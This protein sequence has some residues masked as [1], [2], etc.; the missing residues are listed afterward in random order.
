MK[1]KYCTDCGRFS[2]N[3]G[4]YCAYC[5]SR[6]G[7]SLLAPCCSCGEY[8][9]VNHKFCIY[10]GAECE[11]VK[12][13]FCTFYE[14]DEED[15]SAC[16][17]KNI[18]VS[19]DDYEFD[20]DGKAADEIIGFVNA[21]FASASAQLGKL[22]DDFRKFV[23]DFGTIVKDYDK[24]KKSCEIIEGLALDLE[25]CNGMR[26]IRT[27]NGYELPENCCSEKDII[28]IPEGVNIIG[29]RAFENDTQLNNLV[30]P[31]SVVRIGR[32]AFKNS[33]LVCVRIPKCVKIIDD[34]A[35]CF[36]NKIEKV[37][38]ESGPEHIGEY[39]FYGC[40]SLK[41]V[42]LPENIGS[43]GTCAFGYIQDEYGES[44]KKMEDFDIICLGGAGRDYGHENGFSLF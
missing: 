42:I 32:D 7:T 35:F 18:I 8:I 21:G 26:I 28:S 24:L 11:S 29:D 19:D 39:A 36:C 31:Q 15:L 3:S 25:F 12:G 10:C 1:L 44:V 37:I 23:S 16:D 2:K 13:N 17:N 33:S 38:F 14:L 30:I 22:Q 9:S 20:A 27:D 40:P 4:N 34:N 5:G 43:I 41:E 6:F